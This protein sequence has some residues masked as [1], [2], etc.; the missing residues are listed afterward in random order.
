MAKGYW[1]RPDET[2]RTFSA[3]LADTGQGPFLRTG[4]LGFVLH[5]ELFIT[6]RIKDLIIVSG[7]NL[8][9]QDIEQVAQASHPACNPSAARRSLWSTT[10]RNGSWWRTRS[11]ASS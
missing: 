6:G 3:Y 1:N 2:E 11:S 10:A 7:R 8:Y 4:D 9:P 5:G